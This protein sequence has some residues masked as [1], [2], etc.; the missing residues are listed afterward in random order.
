MSV[1]KHPPHRVQRDLVVDHP[2]ADGVAELVRGD[3]DRPAGRV[4]HVAVGKPALQPAVEPAPRRRPLAVGVF[5]DRGQQK[6]P[7][8]GEALEQILPLG[9]DPRD[10]PVGDGDDRLA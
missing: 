4:A 9:A 3:L 2:R 8:R 1:I 10:E 5:A 7:R 6:P